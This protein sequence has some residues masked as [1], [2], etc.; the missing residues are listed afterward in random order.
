MACMDSCRFW[1]SA[2]TTRNDLLNL[3]DSEY[4]KYIEESGDVYTEAVLLKFGNSLQSDA[5][6][7]RFGL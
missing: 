1:W 5:E 6:A 7:I 4:T 2:G 3:L